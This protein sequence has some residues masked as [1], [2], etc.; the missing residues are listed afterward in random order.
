MSEEHDV[1]CAG[2]ERT[3]DKDCN[4]TGED[5]V[6]NKNEK[7]NE[8][9]TG[10]KD[11]V[12]EIASANVVSATNDKESLSSEI[13]EKQDLYGGKGSKGTLT[14]TR[15]ESSLRVSWNLYEGTAT[16]KDY[17]ALCYADSIV[18][19][20]QVK[21]SMSDMWKQ[22]AGVVLQ[23]ALTSPLRKPLVKPFTSSRIWDEGAWS[24]CMV[25]DFVYS[26]YQSALSRSPRL[27]GCMNGLRRPRAS[28][29]ATRFVNECPTGACLAA[30]VQSRRA[31][32]SIRERMPPFQIPTDR[33]LQSRVLL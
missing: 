6:G 15:E 3:E 11:K 13:D 21:H 18:I 32:P 25:H 17:V 5:E 33:T 2:S 12:E 31:P 23:H 1:D 28:L 27:G 24:F 30:H 8:D 14:W 10:D 19:I 22:K 29:P 16:P 9:N 26:G 20:I 4:E 7:D